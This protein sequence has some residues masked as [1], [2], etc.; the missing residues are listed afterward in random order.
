MASTLGY[1]SGAVAH[2]PQ[3]SG[4]HRGPGASRVSEAETEPLPF[5]TYLDSFGLAAGSPAAAD[6]HGRPAV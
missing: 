5:L 6:V 2:V 1:G 3:A 4:S